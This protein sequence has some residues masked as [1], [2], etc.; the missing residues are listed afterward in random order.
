MEELDLK[1]LF[2]IVLRQWWILL[3]TTVVIIGAAAVYSFFIAVSIYQADTTIYVGRHQD[4][5]SSLGY[6]DLLMGAQLVNDYR[7]LVKSRMVS[8]RV[9]NELGLEDITATELAKSI[10]V[11]SVK[12][13]RLIEIT[14]QHPDPQ[15]ARKIADKVAEVF[16]EVVVDVMKIENVQ[17][18]DRAVMPNSPVKPNK[19]M[20]MAIAAVLGLMLG[21]GIIFVIE[22]FDDT[23]KTPEDVE[24]YLEL[25]VIGTIPV[26]KS[27]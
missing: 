13:T 24:K 12:D 19:M 20:N 6:N 3:V 22:Y 25:P 9:I 18:I 8:Y 1:S 15:M 11:N 2:N 23:L 5:N 17:I 21:F 4:P 26:F 7:E 10:S 27:N 16:S 14:A